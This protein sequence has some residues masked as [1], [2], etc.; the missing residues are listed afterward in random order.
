MHM[1]L[2]NH[3]EIFTELQSLPQLYLTVPGTHFNFLGI[4]NKKDSCAVQVIWTVPMQKEL[5][6][7]SIYYVENQVERL[8]RA[9]CH[10]E[11]QSR[12]FF[13]L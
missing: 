7:R 4:S 8:K 1:E 6:F 13:Q 11:Q 2:C 10:R 3:L 12:S 5:K 9:D